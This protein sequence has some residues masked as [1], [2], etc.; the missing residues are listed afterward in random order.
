MCPS[1][2]FWPVLALTAAQSGACAVTAV[3]DG[4]ALVRSI[5][6]A[7]LGGRLLSGCMLASLQ[8]KGV[9]V[10]PPYSFKRVQG[11]AGQWEAR[12]RLTA[13]PTPLCSMSGPAGSALMLGG[14]PAHCTAKP[15]CW[16]KMLLTT[17]AS[18]QLPQ[19][20]TAANCEL[21]SC[22]ACSLSMHYD[23][24]PCAASPAGEMS[25]ELCMQVVCGM[26]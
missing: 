13:T 25:W 21:G 24:S 23:V 16:C 26:A 3:H 20:S 17:P 4:Y 18:W 8:A 14:S 2:V 19:L 6:R 12:A 9:A 11:A 10:Q 7:P 15:L 5:A 1:G 22:K